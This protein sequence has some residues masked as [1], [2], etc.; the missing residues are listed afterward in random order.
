MQKLETMISNFIAVDFETA[1]SDKMACQVGITIVE[2]NEIKNTIVRLIQPPANR[3][4]A[5]CIRVHHIT[6]EQTHDAPS[7]DILW[8]EIGE[9]FT[10]TT[11][12]AHNAPFDESVLRTNLEYYGISHDN[13]CKFICTYKLYGL[14]LEKLCVAFDMPV[15]NH[16][17]AGFDSI[18]CAKF[19][20]NYLNGIKP[21]ISMLENYISKEQK[22]NVIPHEQL[23]G[24]I[25]QKDLT[26]ADSSNPF[27]NKKVVITGIFDVER[28]IL[29][30][31]L[32]SLG[33]DIDTALSKLTDYIIIGEDAGPAKLAKL[34]SLIDA[35]YSI[36]K[37]YNH[38]VERIICDDFSSVISKISNMDNFLFSSSDKMQDNPFYGKRIAYTGD[39]SINTRVLIKNLKAWGADLNNTISKATNLVLIGNNPNPQKI[40]KLETLLH[41]GFHIRKIYQD[42]LDKIF[43]GEDWEL[44]T[45]EKE[46]IK[47]LDFTFEHFNQ[48]H[49][50]FNEGVRNKIAGK[51]LYFC[52]GFRKDKVAIQQITGNLAAWGNFSL[53]PQIQVF[54][55]S[56]KTVKMLQNGE[57][58]DNI[59]MIEN[60][61]NQNKTEKFDFSFMT[62]DDILNFAKLWCTTYNDK[63]L[64]SLYE[65]Y[66]SS[67]Y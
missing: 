18:C 28:N 37:L 26:N 33:A 12:V 19:Y 61:Y 60:Y 67:E 52:E 40:D 14:S 56:N 45:T 48:H 32:K 17:D 7:F 1:N 63:V 46:N 36:C 9:L 50:Q 8:Q 31:K 51:E 35:G 23:K 38:D 66:M 65:R 55:L 44:Y 54:V 49:F 58:D 41:D 30:A 29:A 62:E 47:A 24:S 15:S 43:R 57:K 39:F 59:R 13:I 5:G 4:D 64:Y 10:N 27:Y 22:Q 16:H 3:Y 11:I 2:N 20:I 6:P 34:S 42:D 53:S 25:L 21:D